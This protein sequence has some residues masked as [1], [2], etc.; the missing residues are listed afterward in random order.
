MK[1]V[2]AEEAPCLHALEA[3]RVVEVFRPRVLHV[4]QQSRPFVAF[5]KG[6]VA[7]GREQ[8]A[9]DAQPAVFGQDAQGVQVILAGVGLV[10]HALEGLSRAF[11]DAAQ[12]GAAQFVQ[13]GAVIAHDGSGEILLVSRSENLLLP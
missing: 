3:Q 7:Q 11:L 9:A 10:L 5:G 13:A 12:G 8:S 6:F 2:R 1:K 4:H